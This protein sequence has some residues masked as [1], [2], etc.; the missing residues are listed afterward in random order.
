MP[1]SASLRINWSAILCGIVLPPLFF[2][3]QKDRFG[4]RHKRRMPCRDLQ[5]L[6]LRVRLPG[7][8]GL[9]QEKAHYN[10]G[11]TTN[12]PEKRALLKMQMQVRRSSDASAD[13]FG[14]HRAEECGNTKDQEINPT[15][16]AALDVIRID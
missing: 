5:R 10:R 4:V 1:A 11:R 9:S 13:V 8:S 6:R 12:D 3:L 15:S 7:R 16:R 14:I 2:P